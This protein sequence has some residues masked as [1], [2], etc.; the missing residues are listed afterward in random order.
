MTRYTVNNPSRD[1]GIN[2]EVNP[3]ATESDA[4]IANRTA[5]RLGLHGWAKQIITTNPDSIPI[6]DSSRGGLVTSEGEP[7]R[8]NGLRIW[9][10]AAL[11]LW[12]RA[13]A[14]AGEYGERPVVINVIGDSITFGITTSGAANELASN[15]LGNILGAW[16]WPVQLNRLIASQLGTQIPYWRDGK[17]AR[18]T[19]TG[20]GSTLNIGALGIRARILGAGATQAHIAVFTN[21]EVG[22]FDSS[23][24]TGPVSASVDGGAAT[25]FNNSGIENNYKQMPISGLSD[26]EHSLIITGLGPNSAFVTNFLAWR[27]ISS[28]PGVCFAAYGAPGWT[29]TDAILSGGS[30][31]AETPAVQERLLAAIVSQGSPD[32]YFIGFAHNDG[33][34][35]DTKKY[36]ET[37]DR[38]LDRIP[39]E[40]FVLL[41]APPP[42]PPEQEIG[43][44]GVRTA[45][46][47]VMR[48]AALSR[49]NVA[50]VRMADLGDW[51]AWNSNGLINAGS[52]H[53]TPRGYHA[54]AQALAKVLV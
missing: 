13:L 18:N 6:I 48:D 41:I 15:A 14:K 43:A 35:I 34:Y 23:A 26:A 28:G 49:P 5:E 53:P 31:P 42:P 51:A 39:S 19:N 37:M 7:I 45:Y 52:V 22:L 29:L 4:D 3:V 11:S 33:A 32:A 40:K 54:I 44:F 8:V 2:L 25:N 38:I 36:A 1:G 24:A 9:N 12:R 50:H 21:A 47:D 20:G 46:W 27:K 17:D 16:R 10:P 30:K